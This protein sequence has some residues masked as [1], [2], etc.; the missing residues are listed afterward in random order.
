MQ[1]EFGHETLDASALE[2]GWHN[3]C[4]V[5]TD[6]YDFTQYNRPSFRSSSERFQVQARQTAITLRM[7]EDHFKQCLD[8]VTSHV[9]HETDSW[10]AAVLVLI[11]FYGTTT[12]KQ[13]HVHLSLSR[14]KSLLS[15]IQKRDPS[16]EDLVTKYNI[17]PVDTIRYIRFYTL[18]MPVKSV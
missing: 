4:A 6:F 10:N 17:T 12:N 1:A 11:Y 2:R 9:Q 14:C 15:K 18:W 5:L 3:R 7:T 16:V 8:D 13:G